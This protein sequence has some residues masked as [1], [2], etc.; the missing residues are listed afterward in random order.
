MRQSHPI[1]DSDD[2]YEVSREE[3][4]RDLQGVASL[5][6]VAQQAL[7]AAREARSR[8]CTEA[9]MAGM[10]LREV[11]DATGYSI[12]S[13]RRAKL[14]EN[15]RNAGWYKARTRP[16]Q[17]QYWDGQRWLLRFRPE[18]DGATGPQRPAQQP[19]RSPNRQPP[20]AHPT[21]KG[22]LSSEAKRRAEA[23]L[24][25]PNYDRKPEQQQFPGTVTRQ[26]P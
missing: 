9:L 15:R 16:S 11:S 6:L 8:V 19:A 20:S 25:P 21:P 12:S 4:L 5:N 17:E 3:L 26:Q 18:R 23:G 2:A 24:P 22:G 10:T 14:S 13:V 7:D 1:G